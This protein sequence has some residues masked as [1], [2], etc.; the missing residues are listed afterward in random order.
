VTDNE[1]PDW[2]AWGYSHGSMYYNSYSTYQNYYRTRS[3]YGLCNSMAA[4]LGY[5][6][7]SGSLVNFYTYNSSY[8][9]RYCYQNSG[10]Y[11]FLPYSSRNSCIGGYPGYSQCGYK[12]AYFWG[13]SYAYNSSCR[14][15]QNSWSWQGSWTRY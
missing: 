11:Y 10:S 7:Y 1:V 8:I 3:Y 2:S 15:Y 9:N 14:C 5:P 12:P 6:R 13:Q 4:Y